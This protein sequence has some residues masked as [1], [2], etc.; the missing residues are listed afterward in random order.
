VTLEGVELGVV[1]HLLEFPANPVMA[2]SGDGRERWIPLVPQ[3]LKS[4]DL[5]A[6]RVTVD[7]DPEF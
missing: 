3:H 5:E 4:F 1:R 2:V 6:K 7:W